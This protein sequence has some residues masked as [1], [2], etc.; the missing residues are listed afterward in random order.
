[1]KAKEKSIEVYTCR[2]CGLMA[3]QGHVEVTMP[4]PTADNPFC[5]FRINCC[6]C[7][8]ELTIQEKESWTSKK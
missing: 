6:G 5:D 4:D 1:M 7:G 8:S 2:V 3:D